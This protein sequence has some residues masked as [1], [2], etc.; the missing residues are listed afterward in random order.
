MNMQSLYS[1]Q[2]VTL[3]IAHNSLSM[4]A[5]N[6]DSETQIDFE[7][8][9]L[10]SGISMAANLREAFR[11]STLLCRGYGHATVLLDTPLIL[12]PVEEFQEEDKE[13]LYNYSV[14]GHSQDIVVSTVLPDENAVA[15]YC[16]NKDLKL[17][18]DDHFTD[19]RLRPLMYSVW[20]RMHR[21]GFSMQHR[22]LFGYFHDGKLEIFSFDK[23][24]FRYC[25]CF[26]GAQ[27]HDSVYFLLYVWNQLG[28]DA[29]RD[30]M[31]LWGRL[32][33]QERM[34]TILRRYVQQVHVHSAAAAF[35]RAP[36]TGIKG[37]QL[38]MIT[39]FIRR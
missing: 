5:I 36:I 26:E 28:M 23:N 14:S 33:E 35:N 2:R 17:V 21:M 24:R 39:H 3:R 10:K 38:D 4:A 8:Y 34:M 16:I 11:E 19:V 7:P 9:I 13:T 29:R 37:I 25:N 6:H 32:P 20:S 18:L 12:F 22:R 31:H 1:T 15:V 30:E 27:L